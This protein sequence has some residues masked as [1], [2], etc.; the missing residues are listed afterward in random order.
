MVVN[1]NYESVSFWDA[2]KEGFEDYLAEK[3]TERMEAKK[4]RGEDVSQGPSIFDG[5]A[6]FFNAS[7]DTVNQNVLEPVKT[8]IRN[9]ARRLDRKVRQYI[10]DGNPYSMTFGEKAWNGVKGFGKFVDNYTN[11]ETFVALGTVYLGAG[12]L[13][14][15]LPEAWNICAA[16]ALT[17]GCSAVGG[18]CTGNGTFHVLSADN[19]QEAQFGGYNI[20]NGLV[21]LYFANQSAKPTLSAAKKFGLNVKNPE[22][23]S[24]FGA[25]MENGKILPQTIKRVFIVRKSP[26]KPLNINGREAE[27]TILSSKF[28]P[29]CRKNSA[30]AKSSDPS[31]QNNTIE[32]DNNQQKHLFAKQNATVPLKNASGAFAFN[33]AEINCNTNKVP[34][35]FILHHP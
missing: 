14:E 28:K 29:K 26:G 33:L 35:N 11:A 15:V 10:D 20:G 2:F 25:L 22:N 7:F 1:T 30:F 34:D 3:L 19:E 32:F 31:P 23:L 12:A 8:P 24:S 5:Y 18:Y 27:V 6:A 21:S 9:G 17:T 16:N 4:A 13:S